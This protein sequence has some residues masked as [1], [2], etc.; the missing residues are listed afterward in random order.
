MTDTPTLRTDVMVL[1]WYRE[2]AFKAWAKKAFGV[3]SFAAGAIMQAPGEW[4]K[5]AG[6]AVG[7]I[8]ADFLG[9]AYDIF[10]GGPEVFQ[11]PPLEGKS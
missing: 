10:F 6:G 8:V 7:L 1:P 4:L 3:L 2:S 9:S 11:A 5:I